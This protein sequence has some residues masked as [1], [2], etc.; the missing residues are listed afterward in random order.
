VSANRRYLTYSDGTP[1][2]WLGDTWWFAP[3][4]LVPFDGSS[5]PEYPS[6]YKALIDTRRA[7]GFSV[8]HMAFLGPMAQSSGVNSFTLLGLQRR[9]DVAYWR[10]VDRYI[11][12]ANQAGIVPVIGLA[13]HS[14]VDQ[15][16]LED[17]KFLWRA[18][19]ARYGA[20]AVTWLICGEYNA[21][22]GDV[23]GR[24]PM[25]LALGQYIKDTDPYQRAM[26][27]HPWWF[28]GDKRQAWDQPWYD[29]IML[30]GAHLTYPDASLY[31]DAYRRPE[32]KPVLEGECNYEGIKGMTDY[33]VRWCAYR[34]IQSGSF[35]Y[36]YGAH[37]L[38]YPT[39][40]IS[41]TTFKEWGDPIPWWVALAAPGGAQMRILRDVY[42]SVDWWK[43]EPR[44]EAFKRPLDWPEMM[45]VAVKAD[46]DDTLVAYI[47]RGVIKTRAVKLQ[48]L[49]AGARYGGQWVNPRTGERTDL[50]EPLAVEEGQV[51]LPDRRSG[52]DWVM[53]LRRVVAQR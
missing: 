20:H 50:E 12:Y 31:L 8:A 11:D 5:N 13:F 29:F 17:W 25:V 23:A 27:V 1:F 30:Q 45:S 43:L 9:I 37:G 32:A 6:M 51:E 3:S 19:I 48:G 49:P 34:A 36:T 47:P 26:T 41:D 24:V 4:S 35:G 44:P 21:D 14:G 18:V 46:G 40:S 33:D 2:F 22:L 15:L 28:G 10:E 52:D 53:V 42:E 38:W 39:Q 16:S 7:Q